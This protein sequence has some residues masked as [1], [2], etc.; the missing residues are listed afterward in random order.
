MNLAIDM[1]PG[2][3]LCR[4]PVVKSL[5]PIG[6]IRD[7]GEENG[8]KKGQAKKQDTGFHWGPKLNNHGQ[9]GT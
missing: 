5:Y 4:A 6:D 8:W 3:A 7:L 2:D 9:L 1:V